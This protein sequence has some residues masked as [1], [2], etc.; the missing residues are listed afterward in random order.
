LRAVT[1]I[2]GSNQSYR[3][4]RPTVLQ[5]AI[6]N[7]ASADRATAIAILSSDPSIIVSQI[8][9]FA[10]DPLLVREDILGIVTAGVQLAISA[11]L[12]EN[13]LIYV[14]PA[15]TGQVALSLFFEDIS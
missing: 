3:V 4:D 10:P 5:A 15:G 2:T 13:D 8:L 6:L 14:F 12:A 9:Q 1:I 7:C 11:V